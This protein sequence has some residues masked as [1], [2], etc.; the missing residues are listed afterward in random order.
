MRRRVNYWIRSV[1]GSFR[2]KM[3]NI[4]YI[5]CSDEKILSI[6]R[7]YLNHDYYTDVITFDYTEDGVVSGDIFISIDTV[8]SN[9]GKFGVGYGEELHRVMIHGVLHL[10][11][12]NDKSPEERENMTQQ[13]NIALMRLSELK[14]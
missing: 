1:I 8:R 11:G 6:N 10:C 13:E 2:K 12:V 7:Q 4:S 3:G 14:L 9:A 5:F